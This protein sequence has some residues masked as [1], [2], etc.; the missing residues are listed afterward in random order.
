M[1]LIV[2]QKKNYFKK[3]KMW[4]QILKN[5]N[6]EIFI[7]NFK[8]FVMILQTFDNREINLKIDNKIEKSIET[9][10]ETISISKIFI[11]SFDNSVLM[12][13]KIVEIIRVVHQ[14]ASV[15]KEKKLNLKK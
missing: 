15:E 3:K 1:F 5:N 10:I 6:F 7:K 4:Q 14:S 12:F 9:E 13:K 8:I 2:D 11:S